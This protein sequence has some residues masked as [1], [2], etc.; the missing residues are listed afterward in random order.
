M[1]TTDTALPRTVVRLASDRTLDLVC[2]NGVAYSVDHR[3]PLGAP[4]DSD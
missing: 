1:L 3:L 4:R 2:E